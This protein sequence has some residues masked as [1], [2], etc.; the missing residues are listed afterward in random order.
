[1]ADIENTKLRLASLWA[2]VG[3]MALGVWFQATFVSEQRNAVRVI[4]E[5]I[6]RDALVHEKDREEMVGAIREVRDEIR[7]LVSDL[8][9][10]R[11]ANSWLETYQIVFDAWLDAL[12][13]LNPTLK[14]PPHKIPPL[15]R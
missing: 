12:R 1:M 7:K 3:A 15:P 8:V 5:T 11:Q 14:V 9:Q 2:I 13:N 10:A 6:E 4:Q